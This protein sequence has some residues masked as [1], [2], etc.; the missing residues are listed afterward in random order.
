MT[1]HQKGPTHVAGLYSRICKWCGV[2]YF[3][4]KVSPH[5]ATHYP[6][7]CGERPAELQPSV[8]EPAIVLTPTQTEALQTVKAM[9]TTYLKNNMSQFTVALVDGMDDALD[10]VSRLIEETQARQLIRN[11]ETGAVK[12]ANRQE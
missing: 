11:I 8:Y 4:E 6:D 5:Q 12:L 10:T 9:A 3:Q 2:E 7:V 1:K